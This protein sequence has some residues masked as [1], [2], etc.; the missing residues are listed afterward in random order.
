VALH[1]G[2]RLLIVDDGP[3]PHT[4]ANGS[5]SADQRP[6]PGVEPGAPRVNN[7]ALNSNTVTLGPF[8]TPG[9][10]HLY[11]TIHPGMTLTVVV[12]SSE[13]I[14]RTVWI[15]PNPAR[16]C[17]TRVGRIVW[18]KQQSLQRRTP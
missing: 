18:K 11:C 3:V 8:T 15:V 14:S 6:V 2:E 9:T 13:E 4:L 7:V 5:W 17:L 1:K 12:E 16:V 10:Y